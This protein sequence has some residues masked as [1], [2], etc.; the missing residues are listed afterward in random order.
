VR[1]HDIV[2]WRWEAATRDGA[3]G[4]PNAAIFRDRLLL[5][6]EHAR[7][8]EQAVCVMILGVGGG[9]EDQLAQVGERLSASLRASD[10]VARFGSSDL[11]LLL[12]GLRSAGD[13]EAV[14]ER[15]RFQAGGRLT[16]FGHAVSPDD[17]EDAESLLLAA[18]RRRDERASL[19]AS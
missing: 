2:E 11:A 1:L 17:A 5:A 12:P 15:L 10:T 8:R 13:V 7:R 14:V 18:T 6:L 4:L 19:L 16:G 9:D 3:T